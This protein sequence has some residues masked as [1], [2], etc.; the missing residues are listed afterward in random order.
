MKDDPTE[1]AA[2]LIEEHGLEDARRVVLDSIIRAQD[3]GD[4]YRLSVWREVRQ[5]LTQRSGDTG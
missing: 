2:W 3:V 4:N 5:V 1:I